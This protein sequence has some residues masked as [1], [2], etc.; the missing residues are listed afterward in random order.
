MNVLCLNTAF[1]KADVALKTDESFC[2]SIDSN[3]KHSENLL[4]AVQEVLTRAKCEISD[5]DAISVIVGPGSFTGLRIGVATAKAFL[6]SNK[7]LR[8]VGISSL[9]LLA[10]S[11]FKA[12]KKAKNV[13]VLMDAISER[14]FVAEFDRKLN[15]LIEP[16]MIF[17]NELKDVIEGKTNFAH[18]SEDD[19]TFGAGGIKIDPIDMLELTLKKISENKFCLEKDLNPV[20]LRLSQAEEMLNSKKAENDN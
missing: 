2:L 4:L 19:T 5:I 12:D 8:A 7:N 20:Y 3:S 13:L 17:K 6:F 14:F 11:Y 15:A 9:E 1:K 16:K 10:Y 18:T